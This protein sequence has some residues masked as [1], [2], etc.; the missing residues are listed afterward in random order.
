MND[1][2]EHERRETIAHLEQRALHARALEFF[3]FQLH[4]DTPKEDIDALASELTGTANK[5]LVVYYHAKGI[6]P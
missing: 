3:A 2:L 4:K 1:D 5:M 6:Q